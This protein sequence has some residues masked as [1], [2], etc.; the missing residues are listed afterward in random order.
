MKINRVKNLEIKRN[1]RTFESHSHV[2]D[3]HHAQ[4]RQSKQQMMNRVNQNDQL[5]Q[6]S[7]FDDK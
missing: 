7:L 3:Q 2:N 6:K 4:K 1:R 5:F